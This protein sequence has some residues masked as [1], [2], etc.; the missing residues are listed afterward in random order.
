MREPEYPAT[1]L[2]IEDLLADESFTK[3]LNKT[4][5]VIILE[6]GILPSPGLH[7]AVKTRFT[8]YLSGVIDKLLEDTE[9][10]AGRLGIHASTA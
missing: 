9:V 2:I 10:I 7:D 8:N 6:N 4:I 3:L 1:T 5:T